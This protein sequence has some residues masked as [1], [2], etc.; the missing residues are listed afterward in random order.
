MELMETLEALADQVHLTLHRPKQMVEQVE[1]Q[2][3][4]EL[5]V[6]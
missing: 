5:V 1:M 6:Q 3:Q 4:E 2:L